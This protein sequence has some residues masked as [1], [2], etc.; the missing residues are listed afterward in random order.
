M[1]CDRWNRLLG[2]WNVPEMDATCAF[3]QLIEAYATPVRYYH[4]LDHVAD[5]VRTV[6]SLARHAPN[7]EAVSRAA[8]LHDVVY[9]SR[10]SDN[11]ELSAAYAER[12]C[13]TLSIPIGALTAT[14]ILKT[15]THD[16]AGDADARVLIDADLAILGASEPV[17]AA[18]ANAIRRE[19]AWVP[20]GEYRDGR[21]SD[22]ERFLGRPRLYHLLCHL[23]D[24]ARRN[25]AVEI[26]SLAS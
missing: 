10:R 24:A 11:E 5:V 1:K 23:E 7:L 3:D 6:E 18:Y 15:K 19:Y 20:E 2:V 16:A 8:W 14:L 9:D 4:T 22:L 17:Y 26:A 13:Q 25:L 12:L 21:R